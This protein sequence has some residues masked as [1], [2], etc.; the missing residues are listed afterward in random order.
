MKRLLIPALV[1]AVLLVGV[2]DAGARSTATTTVTVEVIGKGTV[3]SN[4]S[5][6][7]CGNGNKKCFITFS[8]GVTLT[9]KPSSGWTFSGWDDPGG[10]PY[11]NDCDGSG[12]VSIT[13]L[14]KAVNCQLGM[15]S[16]D[17]S[18]VQ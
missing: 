4:V 7:N 13:E 9:A 12:Q 15:A 14:Q 8:Q 2:V 17:T 1:L 6:I 5:G 16:C 10:V 11:V 3:K 18:C